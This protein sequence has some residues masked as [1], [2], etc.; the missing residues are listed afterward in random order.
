MPNEYTP[1]ATWDD[2]VNLPADGDDP[3][4]ALFNTA[5]EPTLDRTEYL[6][7]AM[8]GWV[9]S[10]MSAVW[11][12]GAEWEFS[13]TA[14]GWVLVTLP[15]A[16]PSLRLD[17][18]DLPSKGRITSFQVWIDG[19][20]GG[21]SHGGNDFARPNAKLFRHNITTRAT[22]EVSAPESE[23]ANVAAYEVP[24]AIEDDALNHTI[25]PNSKYF[26]IIEGESGTDAETDALLVM[27]ARVFVE[28]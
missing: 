8:H 16:G 11:I 18:A 28:P 7:D 25:D 12:G 13:P 17:F 1:V 6:K 21:V 24:H 19:N 15:A 4:A 14:H 20:G 22:E 23:A 26:V 3:E 2:T 10:G 9:Y 27:G 5:Y